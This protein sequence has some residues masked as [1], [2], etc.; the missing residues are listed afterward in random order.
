MLKA[1]SWMGCAD[2]LGNRNRKRMEYLDYQ[3]SRMGRP[4]CWQQHR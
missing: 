2:H 3:G 4:G 1:G